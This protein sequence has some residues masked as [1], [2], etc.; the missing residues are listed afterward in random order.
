MR[1]V[2]VGHL[3]LDVNVVGGETHELA[4]GGVMQGAVAAARLGANAVVLTKCKLIDRARWVVL[5]EAGVT[6]RRRPSAGTTSIRNE[7]PSDDPDDRRSTLVA[8]ADPFTAADF[9]LV[10][11]DAWLLNPLTVGELPLELLPAIRAEAPFLGLDA[12][13][14]LRVAGPD[15]S[16]SHRDLPDKAEVLAQL[17]LFKADIREAHTLTGETEPVAAAKALA[18][19]GPRTVL[20]THAGGVVVVEAS[21]VVEA[22]FT[23]GTLEGRTGRGDT[24]TAA[25]MVARQGADMERATRF[26]AAV[27]SIK[28]GYRGPYRGEPVEL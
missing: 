19:L 17:D 27:T 13:G 1:I 16:L 2:F 12:G 28:M 18:E 5:D 23:G 3:C 15:G 6:V 20:L 4:G 10:S 14:L 9:E 26:A 7:Y 25:F 11:A 21:D 24:C 22:P 8:R